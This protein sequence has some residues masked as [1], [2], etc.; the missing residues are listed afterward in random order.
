VEQGKRLANI[1]EA[2]VI[3]A[4]VPTLGRANSKKISNY[5]PSLFKAILIDEAHH[6]VA[7]TY[8]NIL[9]HFKVDDPDSKILVW[10][11]SATVKRHDGL[12][13]RDVFDKI[14][15]HV[16]FLQMIR[17][18]YLCQMKVTMVHTNIDLDGVG[19]NKND[20]KLEELSNAINIDS[21]NEV[22]ISSWRKFAHDNGRKSTL[23]FAA[24]IAHTVDLCN[25]F[26]DAGINAAFI[27]ST[28]P[29]LT[30][31]QILNDF[32]SGKIAVLVNCGK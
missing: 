1:E 20:F 2:D 3:V 30:R 22:I 15:Y 19:R 26:L 24:D 7:S 29:A 13:L 9:N 31:Y 25:A 10:G 11:C 12:S 21:R 23:V 27:T 18:G 28:T 5:D 6:A 4:S 16:D 32:R 17:E 8:M 14:T